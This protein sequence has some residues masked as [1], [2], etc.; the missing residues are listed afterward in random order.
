M[1]SEGDGAWGRERRDGFLRKS[2][3]PIKKRIQEDLWKKAKAGAAV[4][5]GQKGV[6]WCACEVWWVC[7][8]VVWWLQSIA[9]GK[10]GRGEERVARG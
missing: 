5:K 8:C 9:L 1:S 6:R 4:A 3:A 2:D 10:G 7:A